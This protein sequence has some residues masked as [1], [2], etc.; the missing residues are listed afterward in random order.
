LATLHAIL[1]DLGIL[2]EDQKNVHLDT[3][4][5]PLKSPR[6]FCSMIQVPASWSS[7]S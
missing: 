4:H 2:L 7:A 1:R 3:Q 6:A 5:R